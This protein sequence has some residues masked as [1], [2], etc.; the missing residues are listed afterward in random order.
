MKRVQH[1]ERIFFAEVQSLNVVFQETGDSSPR[2]SE[3]AGDRF[4]AL[5]N[6]VRD[7]TVAV[8][9]LTSPGTPELGGGR[10]GGAVA[11]PAFC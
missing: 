5:E 6:Q 4:M 11:P 7:L 8:M 1:F 3:R 2:V 10:A 9:E